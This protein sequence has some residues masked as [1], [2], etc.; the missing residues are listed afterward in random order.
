MSIHRTI[1]W[2]LNRRKINFCETMNRDLNII[3]YAIPSVICSFATS[4][5]DWSMKNA[6][7]LSTNQKRDRNGHGQCVLRIVVGRQKIR[8]TLST[9][10]KQNKNKQKKKTEKRK[11]KIIYNKK[12]TRQMK[13]KKEAFSSSFLKKKRHILLQGP[14]SR[15]IQLPYQALMSRY[16]YRLIYFQY[17]FSFVTE[18][19][20]PVQ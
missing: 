19:H 6:R 5:C 12:E 15:R 16:F 20:F 3:T 7:N 14:M 1:L 2:E 11:M 4:P 17:I 10:K 9:N 13:Q 8:A 18:R